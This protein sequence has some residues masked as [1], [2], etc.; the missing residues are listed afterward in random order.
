MIIWIKKNGKPYKSKLTEEEIKSVNFLDKK[1]VELVGKG[2]I[3]INY[4]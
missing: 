4:V 3:K 1:F 2:N